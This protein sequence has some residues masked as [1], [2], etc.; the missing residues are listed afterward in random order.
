MAADSRNWLVA[1]RLECG[2]GCLNFV[3]VFCTVVPSTSLILL[4]KS[5]VSEPEELQQ[6]PRAG[7][8]NKIATPAPRSC[9]NSSGSETLD[10]PGRNNDVNDTAVQNRN[11]Y[12]IFVY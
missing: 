8:V 12:R 9:C 4:G 6:F 2:F 1:A 7:P 5:K 10:F 3:P 11:K